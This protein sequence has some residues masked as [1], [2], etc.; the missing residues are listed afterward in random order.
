MIAVLTNMV[1]VFKNMIKEHIYC[2]LFTVYDIECTTFQGR[3]HVND[4]FSHDQHVCDLCQHFE[5]LSG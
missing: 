4:T 1:A 2:D 5:L 3:K